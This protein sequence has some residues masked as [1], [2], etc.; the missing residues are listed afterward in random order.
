MRARHITSDSDYRVPFG[1][2]QLGGTV[3]LAID[4]WDEVP[5]G[6]ELRLWIEGDGE[7]LIPME[8]E[9]RGDATR[10]SVDF[11][12]RCAGIF[13]YTFKIHAVDGSVWSYGAREEHAVG[14][15]AFHY[16]EP[17]SFQITVYVPRATQPAWYRQGVVYQIFP[18]RFFRGSDWRERAKTLEV[19]R[20][21]P[22][23]RLIEDWDTPVS[24]KRAEDGRIAAW[25]FYGGTL[26]GIREKLGYLEALGVTAIYLNPI[27]EAASSHRYDT[28]DYTRI[29]PLLGD[30][31]SFRTLCADAEGHGISIILDGVFNHTG[32]DS[33][34][35]NAFGNYPEVGAAQSPE[36]PYHLW[37]KMGEDGSYSS[38]WGVDDLPDIDEGN[39]DYRAF[40]CGEDGIVRRWLRAGA[41]GWRLDVADELPDS[42]IAELKAAV[43]AERDDALVI[44]EVWEDATHKVAYGELRRYF[45]GTELDGV[46]NYPLR[47]G[48]LRYLIGAAT[49][50]ELADI[51]EQLIENY[52]PEALA[53]CLNVLGTHDRTRLFTILGGAPD[54]SE[55]TEEQRAGYR[56][57]EEQ[58][59]L[60]RS[61][62]WLAALLQM[63]LPGVPCIYYGD[64]LGLEGYTDPYNR[65]PMP[66]DAPDPHCPTIYRNA[67]GLRKAL[68]VLVDGSCEPFAANDDV[69]GFWRRSGAG[70]VCVL[71]NASLE[72]THEVEL[73]MAAPRVSDVISGR[74][75][76][77]EDGSCT[78]TLWPLGSSVLHFH[79]EVRLQKPLEPGIGVLAHITSV[80]NGGSPGTLGEPAMRF[81]E[82]LHAAGV[83]YWQILPVNPT[84]T[85]GSPYAGLS[86]F[87]GDP[88][89]IE[90][91]DQ[92]KPAF[93][94]MGAHGRARSLLGA[95]SGRS[96]GIFARRSPDYR[97]FCDENAVWLEP[98]AAFCAIKDLLGNDV[99]WWE[100]PERYRAYAPEL[101]DDAALGKGAEHHRRIQYDF[102]AQWHALHDRARGYGI[103][104]IGDMPMYVAADSADVWA[105]PG[106]FDPALLAGAPPDPL[107]PEGQL[108][109]NPT[110]RW[111]V[112]EEEG[113]TWWLERLGRMFR[114]YDYVR[115][116]HFV[117]FSSY[118]GI[119]AGK[120]ALE[121]MWH[122]GP[123][124]KLFKA[125]YDRFGP[126]PLLAEDL[127]TITP[128]VRAL[129]AEVGAP[130]MS[131]VQF[132]DEDVFK[133][134][135]PAPDTVVFTGTHDTTTILAWC[136]AHAAPAGKARALASELTERVVGAKADVAILP[137]QDVLLLGSESR[138]NV[139]GVAEGNWSWHANAQAVMAASDRLAR[140]VDMH[141]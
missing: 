13:W 45:E 109:G 100:W 25:D 83:R 136:E 73:P 23:R 92:P 141:G 33:R 72:K 42:F 90:R 126:L 82:W 17:P 129:L 128:A 34:Y 64:E 132:A 54:A 1:A 46:M 139:P 12:P 62:L 14:E 140:L 125:A 2:V 30:E 36:S 106:I 113:Y 105:H 111:D 51:L 16:G 131:V 43:L 52:P 53:N 84:D 127:G 121:G 15:G 20:T 104:I 124:G 88:A 101:A 10:F 116:D 8:A 91:G 38:W 41:R 49:A 93:A 135:H 95:R 50:P 26:E 68:P 74:E 65:A 69:F 96:S 31:E 61:R 97:H 120:T 80:P 67:I 99:P 58:A 40:I 18:D 137:L 118:F 9:A 39:P 117:G 76:A 59:G 112:L 24:Y 28:A 4:V 32:R 11:T 71:V 138:M 89:L 98:Y 22:P 110:F 134:F 75:V 56:L 47:A 114:L 103:G 107:G 123:G 102:D 119:P 77:V 86:A 122:F 29:D 5:H 133:G 108:W 44:G 130:G 60:A 115:L 3:K 35:F 78:V 79:E 94:P 63:S 21:G 87:A 55:L 85:Y 81:L 6:A 7:A 48:I 27:F 19:P 66:W 57:S 70:C 37:Y